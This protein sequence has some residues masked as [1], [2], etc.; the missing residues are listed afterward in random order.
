MGF[1][2]KREKY[3]TDNYSLWTGNIKI[4]AREFSIV[5]A[6]VKSKRYFLCLSK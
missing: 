5:E 1:A 6:H 3:E 4:G 2:K